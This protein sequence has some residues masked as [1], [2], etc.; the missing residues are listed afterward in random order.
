MS[1][2]SVLAMRAG[3]V[4][5]LALVLVARAADGE[6][7]VYAGDE[8]LARTGGSNVV[9]A[10]LACAMGRWRGKRRHERFA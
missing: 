10:N 5:I 6:A 7:A 9:S 2:V 8:G 3:L 4:A 1:R